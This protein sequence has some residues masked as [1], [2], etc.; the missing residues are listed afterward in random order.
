MMQETKDL[1]GVV[2]AEIDY[3]RFFLKVS[4]V[5]LS[6]KRSNNAK[7][8]EHRDQQINSFHKSLYTQPVHLSGVPQYRAAI[9]GYH[10]L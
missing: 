2:S 5:G 3:L 10:V 4:H 8:Q 9:L 1:V 6:S 7:M